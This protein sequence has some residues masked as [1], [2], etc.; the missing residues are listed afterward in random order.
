L[1]C[2]FQSNTKRAKITLQK[3]QKYFWNN[4]FKQTVSAVTRC[5]CEKNRPKWSLVHFCQNYY[6]PFRYRDKKWPK[7]WI[8]FQFS[9]NPSKVSNRPVGENSPNLVTL[10][11][12]I[13]KPSGTLMCAF[14]NVWRKVVR[15]KEGLK[16]NSLG[17]AVKKGLL[18]RER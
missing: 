13:T 12:S 18:T 16:K 11:I 2:H 10:A 3:G 7:I 9:K 14:H 4:S 6:I 15:D 17:L 1:C 5:I 8:R